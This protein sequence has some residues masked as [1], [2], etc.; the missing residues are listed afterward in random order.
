M[1]CHKN[2]ILWKTKELNHKLK[3]FYGI[4]NKPKINLTLKCLHTP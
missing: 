3:E 1:Q 4:K 2:I